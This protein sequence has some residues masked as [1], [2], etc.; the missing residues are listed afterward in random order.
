MLC[1]EVSWGSKVAEGGAEGFPRLALKQ[2]HATSKGASES[3][4]GHL[5]GCGTSEQMDIG[6][7]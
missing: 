4:K 3:D 6:G 1:L 7:C 5:H 2:A